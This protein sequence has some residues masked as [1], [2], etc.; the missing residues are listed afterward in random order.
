MVVPGLQKRKKQNIILNQDFTEILKKSETSICFAVSRFTPFYR[1][2]F[3]KI[4][5]WRYDFPSLG[6]VWFIKLARGIH[7]SFPVH[8]ST[9][10]YDNFSSQ[11]FSF[12]FSINSQYKIGVQAILLLSALVHT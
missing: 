8:I 2:N 9:L 3:E 6:E 7:T 12:S 5:S 10:E 4:E 1:L 11:T